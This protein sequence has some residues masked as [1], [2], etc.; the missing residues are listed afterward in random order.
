MYS[1]HG[2]EAL[3]RPVSGVGVPV[4][5]GVVVLDTRIGAAH[6]ASAMVWNSAER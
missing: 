1:E 3:M 6:A 5:D 4:V 2:F